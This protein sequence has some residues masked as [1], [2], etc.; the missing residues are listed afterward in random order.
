MGRG[1]R[2]GSIAA[3]LRRWLVAHGTLPEG[4]HEVLWNN[5]DN[6]M[7]V[8]FTRLRSDPAYPISRSH[9]DYYKPGTPQP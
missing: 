4:V 2:K 7:K 6:C 5:G 9:P 8:D 3:Y 1:M